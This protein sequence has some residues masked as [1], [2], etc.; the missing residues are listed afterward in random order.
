MWCGFPCRHRIASP[1][2]SNG[3]VG[4]KKCEDTAEP[5]KLDSLRTRQC[6]KTKLWTH[7]WVFAQVSSKN[8]AW[9]RDLT[10]KDGQQT[11]EHIRCPPLQNRLTRCNELWSSDPQLAEIWQQKLLGTMSQSPIQ[12]CMTSAVQGAWF[13]LVGPLAWQ[14]VP[15]AFNR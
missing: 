15:L 14:L 1:F 12:H 10:K 3:V 11:E 4:M 8:R 6:S 9:F 2:I 7:T 13:L 5:L